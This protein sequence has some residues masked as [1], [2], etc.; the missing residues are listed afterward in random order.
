MS[1]LFNSRA[2]LSFSFATGDDDAVTY[3]EGNTLGDYNQFSPITN[4]GGGIIFSPGLSNIITAN[5]NFSAKPLEGM[6][7][8]YV[9]NTQ[10]VLNAMP[11]FRAVNGPVSVS[12]INPSYA[13]NYL[14]T[15][16][17]L[18]VN[19]RP[20]SDLG[21]ITQLGYFIP[22]ASAFTA[23]DPVFMAKLNISLSY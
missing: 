21:V 18:T 14:G 6:D 20:F 11:F 23:A 5:I 17:D 16:I 22:D 10:F 12:G 2:G 19:L 13:G 3:Y 1:W 7:I 4:G 15:E 9:S 8:P